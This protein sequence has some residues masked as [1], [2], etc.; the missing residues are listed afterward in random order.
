MALASPDPDSN[1]EHYTF[2]VI[3]DGGRLEEV[4][5]CFRRGCDHLAKDKDGN[6]LL[7]YAVE[8]NRVDLVKLLI[9]KGV[10]PLSKSDVGWGCIQLAA[11]RGFHEV[12][13]ALMGRE[14][15]WNKTT[16][17]VSFR[18]SP[19]VSPILK[20]PTRKGRVAK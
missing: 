2:Q 8:V 5:G 17:E 15:V 1:I 18:D 11:A 19:Y 4:E 14:M 13:G 7:H 3:R 9:A 10:D 16:G 20:F 6:T 12:L